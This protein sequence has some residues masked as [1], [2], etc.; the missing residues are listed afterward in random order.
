MANKNK[1]RG[2]ILEYEV[3]D[4]FRERKYDAE[5]ARGSDGRS[6]GL[7]KEVDVVVRG[8]FG[9]NGYAYDM[10]IQCKR[11]KGLAEY[12]T[13]DHADIVCVRKDGR[14]A[15]RLYV[16]PESVL[17]KMLDGSV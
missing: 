7:N 2:D 1:I 13:S 15:E 14:G 16:I 5:R 17:F 6:L 3:R 4:A 12:L 9:K 10:T 11:R 8:F